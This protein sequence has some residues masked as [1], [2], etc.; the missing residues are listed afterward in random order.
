MPAKDKNHIRKGFFIN[1]L[2]ETP[3]VKSIPVDDLVSKTGVK[4]TDKK[5]KSVCQKEYIKTSKKCHSTLEHKA[6]VR[7]SELSKYQNDKLKIHFDDNKMYL[8]FYYRGRVTSQ[9]ADIF[10]ILSRDYESEYVTLEHNGYLNISYIDMRWEISYDMDIDIFR[11]KVDN[12]LV[13]LKS[14]KQVL[15]AKD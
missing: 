7:W 15:S 8:S 14:C 5:W 12:I 3:Y 2:G 13:Y 9:I 1:S 4:I 6:Y 10:R 11:Q